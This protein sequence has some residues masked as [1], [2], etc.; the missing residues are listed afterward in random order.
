M[1]DEGKDIALVPMLFQRLGLVHRGYDQ[2]TP[3]QDDI[4]DFLFAG[5]VSSSSYIKN[6]LH[7]LI[8]AQYLF[9]GAGIEHRQCGGNRTTWR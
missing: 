8:T 7:R 5:G 1:I 4:R 6:M 3:G 2:A 9:R